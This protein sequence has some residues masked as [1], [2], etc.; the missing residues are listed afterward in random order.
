VRRRQTARLFAPSTVDDRYRPIIE[1]EAAV[2]VAEFG[3]PEAG[4][5]E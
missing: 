2:L 5:R 4:A 3:Q 1:P